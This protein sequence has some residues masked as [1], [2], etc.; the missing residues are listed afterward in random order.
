MDFTALAVN[1]FLIQTQHLVSKSFEWKQANCGNVISGFQFRCSS[2]VPQRHWMLKSLPTAPI[3]D[4]DLA[5]HLMGIQKDMVVG[6]G[7]P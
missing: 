6:N 4:S 5:I 1:T 7:S 3:S 2:E